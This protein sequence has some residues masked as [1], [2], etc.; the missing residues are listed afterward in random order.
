MNQFVSSFVSVGSDVTYV[1]MFDGPD[2]KSMGA[3]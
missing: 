1:E 3:G 2:G